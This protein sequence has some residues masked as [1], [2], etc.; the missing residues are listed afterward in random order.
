MIQLF[1]P[2]LTLIATASDSLLAKCVLYLKN[3]NR[4][5]RD[6]IPGEIHTK[7]HERTQLL[8]YGQPL[9]TAINELITIVTP[10]TFH[11]WVREEKRTRKKKLI[12]RPGKSAVLRELVLKIARETGFGYTRILGELRKLGISQVC[13]QTVKNILKEEEI[14]PSPKRSTGTWDQFLKAHAETLWACDFFTKRSVTPRGLIDLYVLVFIH[15][16]TREVLATPST[17]NPDAAWVTQQANAFV[18]QV[19]D[20]DKK[21]TCLIHDRDTKF[22]AEFKQL[23]KKKGIQPKMLPIRSPNLNARVERF[24]QTIKYE[25]LNHFIAFGKVHLNYLVSEFVD[26]YNKHRAHSSR[27]YLPPSSVEPPPELETI[28]LDEIHCEE[29]LGG[30]IKSY[31]RIAA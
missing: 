22:S 1:H 31:K 20:R 11:R 27:E 15:L 9:G 5:L 18:N 8:K 29:H 6:R 10:G 24:V 7:P 16:E 14:G 28:K 4:I 12:G 21:P 2:L 26:Y 3:E 19:A 23:L 13:R 30:L 17:R 25:A